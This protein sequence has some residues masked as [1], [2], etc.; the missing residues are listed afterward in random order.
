MGYTFTERVKIILSYLRSK[1]IYF[2]LRL[3]VLKLIFVDLI[4][5]T[6]SSIDPNEELLYV[7]KYLRK[8]LYEQRNPKKNGNK[9]RDK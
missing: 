5:V 4:K 1:F 8:R 2:F 3:Y 7:Y 6:Y 9:S